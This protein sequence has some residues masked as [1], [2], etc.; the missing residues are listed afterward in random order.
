MW[1]LQQF[2]WGLGNFINLTPAIRAIADKTGERVPVFFS[3]DYVKQCFLDC[4]FMEILPG[5]P[6]GQ[7]VLRSSMINRDM[8]DW[9]YVYL[10]AQK[11]FKLSPTIPHT[12]VDKLEPPEGLGEYDV[13]V[14]GCYTE[15]RRHTKDPGPVAMRWLVNRDRQQYFV[16]SEKDCINSAYLNLPQVSGNIRECLKYISGA[17]FFFGN[18]TGFYHVAN[19][20]QKQGLVLWKDCHWVKNVGRGESVKRISLYNENIEQ[21]I[22]AW[23][24]EYL[25]H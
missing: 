10:I 21:L 1:V 15:Q 19:A 4:D 2:D 7:P 11:L 6:G 9:Q 25:E 13:I 24:R 17:R 12:Y 20:L 22:K 14:N 23:T 16:G 8:P 18:A 3:Q 5:H